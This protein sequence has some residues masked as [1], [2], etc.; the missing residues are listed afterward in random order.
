MDREQ[1]YALL[2]EWV[3]NPNLRKHM[4]AVEACMRAY[5]RK[6]GEDE[7]PWGLVGLLHDLDYERY[8]EAG[9]GSHP[10]VGV[11]ELRRRG[12]PEP[13]CRAILS[14][15]DYSGVARQT[16]LEKALFACDE[17]TGFV[18]AVALVKG[19]SLRNVDVE[20]VIRKM[21]DK[22]FARAVRREDIV[23]GAQE[24]GVPLEDHINL[25][26]EAM[27]GVADALDLA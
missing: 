4:L 13:L 17:L 12:L 21:K 22:A 1:A 16:L 2:C 9:P 5:A 20:S 7:D 8:P 25:V 23:R 11:E 10:F 24:L 19:R 14:H 26:L 3:Q 18:V 27:R 6:F 15:A